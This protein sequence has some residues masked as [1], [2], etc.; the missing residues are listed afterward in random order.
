MVQYWQLRA[1]ADGDK[2]HFFEHRGQHAP[3]ADVAVD[4]PGAFHRRGRSRQR[5]KEVGHKGG[6]FYAAKVGKDLRDIPVRSR[7]VDEWK[8]RHRTLLP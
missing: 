2:Q 6:P 4:V 8:D 1:A 5:L 3:R 7:F